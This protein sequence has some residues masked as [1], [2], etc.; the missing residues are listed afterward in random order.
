MDPAMDR[1]ISK[2]QRPA[3][4]G[5]GM[6]NCTKIPHAKEGDITVRETCRACKTHL[7]VLWM[8]NSKQRYSANPGVVP[9]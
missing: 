7:C 8:D 2:A 1:R 5:T 4:S 6:V 3:M 9:G